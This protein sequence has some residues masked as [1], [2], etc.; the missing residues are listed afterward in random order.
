MHGSPR[1]VLLC[2]LAVVLLSLFYPAFFLHHVV[3]PEASMR[4]FPPWRTLLG[5]YP[6]ASPLAAQAATRLGPRLA[7]M[8]RAGLAAALWEPWIGGGR[9]GW[10]ASAAEGGAP[11]TVA[12]AML[13]R[14]GW[15]WTAL[16]AL[17]VAVA[18]ALSW[19]LLRI[20]GLG[21]GAAGIGAT[22]YAL[23]GAVTAR[24]LGPEGSAV[25]LGPLV[26]IAVAAPGGRWP[27]RAAG[28]AAAVAL[29]TLSGSAAAPFLALA[30]AF[31][32][33]RTVSRHGAVPPW[34]AVAVGALLGVALL[35]PRLWLEAA[36]AEPGLVPPSPQIGPTVSDV[37][38]FTVPFLLGDPARA[39]LGPSPPPV[40]TLVS[41]DSAYLGVVPLAL[42]ALGIIALPM[43]RRA[44][45]LGTGA[46]ALALLLVPGELLAAT[47]AVQRPF[48]VF[49]LI[50]AFLAGVGSD[51]V[52]RHAPTPRW[53][54]LL[55]VCLVFVVLLRMLPPAA[56]LLPYA[57]EPEARLEVPE[58]P[59]LL[60]GVGRMVALG[61]TM[62]PDVPATLGAADVRAASLLREPRYAAALRPRE[63]GTVPFTRALD[64]TLPLLGARWIIEPSTLHVV[65]SDIFART[66]SAEAAV[67]NGG[68]LL[69]VPPGAVRVGLP[70]TLGALHKVLLLARGRREEIRPD[71]A[72]A[73]EGDAW[74][75]YSLPREWPAGPAEVDLGMAIPHVSHFVLWDTSGL[76]L[77]TEQA[78]ARVW[79][80]D[81]ARPLAFLARGLLADED[82]AP[83]NPRVVRVPRGRVG[84]LAAAV[85]PP[86]TGSVV[87]AEVE[88]RRLVLDVSA[89]RPRL[90]VTLLKYR[91]ALWRVTINGERAPTQVVDG[92]WTAVV[93]DRGESHVVAEAV[94]PSW[95]WL[96]GA[97]AAVAVLALAVFGRSE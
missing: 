60:G 75:W 62:P 19:W 42:A 79:E 29:L 53:G 54:N 10:L 12:A 90:L 7:I 47:G 74:R 89:S 30:A 59:G 71:P 32:A 45:W 6:Q 78:G 95:V 5:P 3:A 22:I 69:Q 11:L 72:L 14:A 55:L 58:V 49:A 33:V 91:P 97:T 13:S 35:A 64:P 87:V 9:G 67:E 68:L 51:V 82:P 65:S 43:R 40:E 34:R 1:A 16:V 96:L 25:C 2:L 39:A 46:V 41:S 56:H 37:R 23:S 66:V 76:R 88:P 31:L 15:A 73:A 81:R 38:A 26:L 36:S 20:L 8:A 27:R 93:V 94:V 57:R 63:D 24:W 44:F 61:T 52:A 86:V 85:A 83:A 70:V 80:T 48:A 92:L 50:V 4:A 18:L 84:A 21:A 28:I 17:Q 77:V